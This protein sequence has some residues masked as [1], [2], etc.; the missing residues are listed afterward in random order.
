MSLN[1]PSLRENTCHIDDTASA[2]LSV[3][4]S[5]LCWS[6]AA[7]RRQW[8]APLGFGPGVARKRRARSWRAEWMSCGPAAACYVRAR[9]ARSTEP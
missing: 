8:Q 4:L 5:T 6:L 7:P 2:A 1:G 3:A 9:T